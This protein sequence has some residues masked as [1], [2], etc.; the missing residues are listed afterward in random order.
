MFNADDETLVLIHEKC[1]NIL[2]VF[3]FRGVRNY[4]QDSV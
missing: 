2:H 1:V 3:D 4:N